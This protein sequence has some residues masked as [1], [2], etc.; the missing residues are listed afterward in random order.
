MILFTLFAWYAGLGYFYLW[1][2]RC[3]LEWAFTMAVNV[4]LVFRTSAVVYIQISVHPLT[5]AIQRRP[6]VRG[7][8]LSQLSTHYPACSLLDWV[9]E[10]MR[11]NEN[12]FLM[13]LWDLNSG[14]HVRQSSIITTGTSSL[15]RRSPLHFSCGLLQ[16]LSIIVKTLRKI[17]SNCWTRVTVDLW[18]IIARRLNENIEVHKPQ[19]RTLYFS[20]SW[21]LNVLWAYYSVHRWLG[22]IHLD[23]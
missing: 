6:P 5:A 17:M 10:R 21:S 20:H 1:R 13:W 8:N 3:A 18:E 12:S 15:Y 7:L 14:P 16:L 9:N 4:L 22:R 11:A 19:W 23:C 2:R